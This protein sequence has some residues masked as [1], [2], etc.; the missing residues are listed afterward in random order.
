MSKAHGAISLS[1][2]GL[3]LLM[4][5]SSAG[6]QAVAEDSQAPATTRPGDTAASMQPAAGSDDYQAY[7]AQRPFQAGYRRQAFEYSALDGSMMR[8]QLDLWYP[9]DEREAAYLYLYQRGQVAVDAEVAEGKHPLVLFSHGFM[10]SS[11]QGIYIME[12]LARAGYIVAAVNHNDALLNPRDERPV[13]PRS[14]ELDEWN[15]TMYA[16]RRHDIVTLLDELLVWSDTPGHRFEGRI[17]ADAIAAMGHSLGGYTAMGLAGAWPSWRDERIK[18][19][20]LHSPFVHPFR[21]NGDLGNITIPVMMQ[22]ATFDI[23][24][25]QYLLPIYRRLECPRHYLILEGATHLVWTNFVSVR[26]T[27]VEC[28]DEDNPDLIVDYTIAFLDHFL[29]KQNRS[30]LLEADDPRLHDWAA[31]LDVEQ[32]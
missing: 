26:S 27:T 15:D 28:L 11:D 3:I 21:E 7:V 25:S 14:F 19:A 29:L 24:I 10:G 30:E 12:A 18:V 13:A 17:D 22:G 4:W 20:V 1:V 31:H 6:F 9:T 23:G 2:V 5:A 32:Q 16:D 8:R